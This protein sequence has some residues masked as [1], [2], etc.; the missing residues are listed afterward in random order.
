MAGNK[1]L[2][3]ANATKEDEFY[4]Q[5]SDVEK[6]LKHYRSYFK[7]KI[8]FLNCDDPRESSFWK[9]FELNF[10]VLGIKKLISTHFEDKKPSYKLEINRDD[11]NGGLITSK[12][13]VRTKLKQ[14]GDFRSP[15]AIEILQEADIVITNPPFSLFR[16]YIAQ[17]MEYNKKFIIIGNQNALTYKEIFPLLKDNKMWLGYHCGDMEFIVPSYYEP[18]ATRY[19]EG[20][21]GT[22]YRSLG[23]ICW[24][25]NLD[26][27]KRHENIILYKKYNAQD[28][29]KYDNFNAINV[30][31]V[32]DIP[33]DYNGFMGVPITFLD[34]YNPDQFT[35]VD[36]LNR[37]AL[38]DSQKTN[39]FVKQNHLHT[40]NIDGKSTYFRVVIQLKE[41]NSNGK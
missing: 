21:D 27:T 14:N 34:K 13:I 37:Y 1:S 26:I 15:E 4:T 35:I 31:K 32:A 20:P 41:E 5:L 39:D 33:V 8:I 9:Y 6:E 12:D 16:E 23:N 7:D 22:K 3:K 40:C 11:T 18:R 36:A 2:R 19:R 10:F 17:L 28:Y 38:L 29:P 25:T 30:N 24:F